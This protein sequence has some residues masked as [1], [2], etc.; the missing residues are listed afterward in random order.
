MVTDRELK[1]VLLIGSVVVLIMMATIDAAPRDLDEFTGV[2]VYSSDS[3]SI[4]SNGSTSVGVYSSLQ[5]GVVYRVEGRM[6]NTSSG[7]R[8]R[9]VRIERAEATFPLSAVKGAYWVSSGYYILTPD[10]VRLALPLSAEK[11]ELVEVD[12]IW[13]RNGFYPVRHRVLGFPEEPRDGMPWRIDGTVIYGGTKAVIWNGSE[14]IVL[15]LP[16][17]TKVEAG[18]RVR[19]VG[20]VRFYS[21]L[22]LI[23][24]SPDDISF[25][26]Y[27]EKV[28]VSEAS[29]GDI[30]FGNCTV[31]GAGRSLKL[32]C[33]ELKLR[34]FKARVGDRIYFEAVRR[35][36]SLYC[37]DCRVIESR[38]EIP[39]GIC[40]FSSGELARVFGRVK[41]V[42][43]YKNGF[44]L[45][46]VTDGNCWVLIKLRKSL[47][48][49]LKVNQTVTAYG[50]FTTYR[51]M[52]AFE[53]PSGDDLCSG[54]C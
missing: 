49:S 27:G 50:F 2:C 3:F 54:R 47:N 12:G 13:Y 32:N 37:I 51:G 31:V 20:I 6:Y 24:D 44:G 29:V 14:E 8:I 9:H 15:Y 16:Y 39:N 45:A 41:W 25:V 11:G 18:R 28:P 34:N 10:R 33:T 53:V 5:E 19:V 30:A 35:R 17:G 23:V 21:R 42:R 1:I 36:S 52:P 46:N 7:L 43:V 48:V 40:S 22:S 38:E 4:L 26:G